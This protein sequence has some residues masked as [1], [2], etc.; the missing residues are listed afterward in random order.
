MSAQHHT[1]EG[2]HPGPAKYVKIAAILGAITAIE[3]AVFYIPSLAPVLTPV[4]LVLSAAK[5]TIVAMYYMHLKFD[6]RLYT[7]LFCAGLVVAG[8]I[9]LALLGL[10]GSFT[11]S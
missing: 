2:H 4:L 6:S 8:S 7:G 9:M 1:S 10:F 11:G 3:V 5:F